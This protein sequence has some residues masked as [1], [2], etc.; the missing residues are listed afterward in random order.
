MNKKNLSAGTLSAAL[1]TALGLPVGSALAQT[2]PAGNADLETQIQQQEERI[3]VL[4][5][6]L[7]IAADDAKSAAA[8][9]AVPKASAGGFSIASADGKSVIKLR[10]NL[11][12]DNRH[13]FNDEIPSGTVVPAGSN[14][15]LLRLARPWIDGTINGWIDFRFVPDF[16]QGK[17][18]I[19]DAYTTLRFKPFAQ[20]TVG[21][22][23]SPFGLELLQSDSDI[24]FIERSLVSRLVPNRDIG[25]SLGGDLAGGKVTYALA[26]LNGSADGSSSDANTSADVD[27]NNDKDFVARV[28]S[29]P[30]R[31]GNSFLLRGLGLGIAATYVHA[32]GTVDSTGA[33]VNSLLSSYKTNGQQTFFSYRGSTTPTIAAG[34]R[35]RL[36]PQAYW[37]YNSLGLLGEYVSVKQDVRRTI[38]S[39]DVR[40]GT[41]TDK[42]WQLAAGYFLTGEDAG[43]KYPAPKS[44][45]AVGKPGWGSFELTARIAVLDFDDAAFA[46][47]SASF[48]NPAAAVSK[49]T[50]VTAGVTWQ[51]TQNFKTLL[52]YEQTKFD[53]GAASGDAPTEKV[54]FTRFALSY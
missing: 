45:Y 25:L 35:L 37:N 3:K 48:A 47:G 6:K 22:F 42:G 50:A 15:T 20:L 30:F 31:D 7:E 38:S 8:T 28:F 9:N 43:Y 44:P 10:A 52:N 23:K 36:S 54:L 46:N 16:A 41:L 26:W 4:E 40:E 39:A 27:S 11:N 51:F 18:V 19:Q 12:I 32:T 34:E 13:F 49:A 2:A 24:H 21:K 1:L 53:G 5:R 33:A 29:T 14:T 17:T